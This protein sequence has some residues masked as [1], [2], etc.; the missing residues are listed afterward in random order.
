MSTEGYRRVR[1]PDKK[2]RKVRPPNSRGTRVL[3]F[4]EI[5]HVRLTPEQRKK[6]EELAL[7]VGPGDRQFSTT[8]R[9]MIEEKWEA[10]FGKS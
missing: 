8:V 9:L 4:S 5:V 10:V 1:G 6:L 2:P 7:V 3:E